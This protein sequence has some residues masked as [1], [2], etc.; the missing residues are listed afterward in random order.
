MNLK[1]V[2]DLNNIRFSLTADLSVLKSVRSVPEADI[3]YTVN[4]ELQNYI[5]N[6]FKSRC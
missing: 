1:G 2:Q 4:N 6:P 5:Q 3:A